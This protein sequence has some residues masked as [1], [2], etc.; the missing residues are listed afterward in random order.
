MILI[1][2]LMLIGSPL[3]SQSEGQLSQ[4]REARVLASVATAPLSPSMSTVAFDLPFGVFATTV[5]WNR[6]GASFWVL[7]DS[8]YLMPRSYVE[9]GIAVDWA[10]VETPRHGLAA[11]L[12]T[13][14]GIETLEASVSMPLIV[15]ASY[16]W[17]VL[18]RLS[19]EAACRG[20]LYGQGGGVEL[21]LR[22]LSRPFDQGFLVGLGTGYGFLSEWDFNPH[23]DALRLELTAGY[24]WTGTRRGRP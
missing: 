22:A 13:A 16:R 3:F 19:L 1:A 9:I 8:P 5:P 11:G 17:T 20:M 14:V 24:A 23:G 7:S 18:K 15:K 21:N 12:G 4:I 2:L 10:F 6:A